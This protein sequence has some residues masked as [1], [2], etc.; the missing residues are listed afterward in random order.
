M[1]TRLLPLVVTLALIACAM[2]AAAGERVAS[3]LGVEITRDQL[4][5]A[6]EGRECAMHLARLLWEPVS[7][8]YVE[9]R[10]LAVTA[11]ELEELLAYNAEF[12]RRDRAQRTRKLAEL[13]ERL[14]VDDLTGEARARAVEFRDVLRRMAQRDAENDAAPQPDASEQ[15]AL[16]GPW[17]EMWKLNGAVHREYGGVVAQAVHGHDP[18]G[19]RALLFAEHEREGRLVF[20]DPGL[21][22]A[23][24]ALLMETPR[25]AIRPEDVDFTPHW[26]R[27][28]RGSYYPD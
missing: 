3:F 5:A 7:K 16:F 25:V 26:K 21:R 11:A 13:E 24:Y 17:I 27:P 2:P 10:G 9:T 8:H 20:Y 22:E 18:H 19:A 1:K 23:L 14:R 12:D 4:E 6:A 15:A 28:I